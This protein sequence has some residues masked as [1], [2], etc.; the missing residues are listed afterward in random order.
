MDFAENTPVMEEVAAKLEEAAGQIDTH[1]ENI[2]KGIAGLNE[3]WVGESYNNFKAQC[4]AFA[5]S[6]TAL[7]NVLRAYAYIFK[8]NVEP[9]ADEL[10][11]AVQS[12]LG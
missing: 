2:T 1:A 8:S 11:A 12:A 7:Y 4:D 3:D 6:M 9:A 5:P 10:E